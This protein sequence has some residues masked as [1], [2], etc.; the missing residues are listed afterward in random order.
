RSGQEAAGGPLGGGRRLR[1]DRDRGNVELEGCEGA[2]RRA[3]GEDGE[4]A[5]GRLLGVKLDRAVEGEKIGAELLGEQAARALRG[6]HEHLARRPR[7][8]REQTLLRR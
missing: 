4:V 6:R 5:G 7:Q 2:R 3:G 8:L 1:P